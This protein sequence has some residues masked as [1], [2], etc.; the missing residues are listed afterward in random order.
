MRSRFDLDGAIKRILD[1]LASRL[2][3]GILVAG[4][5]GQALIGMSYVGRA[6]SLLEEA[7]AI[8]EGPSIRNGAISASDLYRVTSIS[9]EAAAQGGFDEDRLARFGV[10]VDILYVR[11]DTLRTELLPEQISDDGIEAIDLLFDVVE[12]S[13]LALQGEVEDIQ[14]FAAELSRIAAEAH[15]RLIRYLEDQHTEQTRAFSS[16]LWA[17][18]G[19]SKQHRAFV[20]VNLFVSMTALALLRRE[21]VAR[22]ARAAAEVKLAHLAFHDSLTDLK[23]RAWF[24]EQLDRRFD[25]GVDPSKDDAAGSAQRDPSRWSLIYADLDEFKQ[26]NDIHGHQ[27][28]DLVLAHVANSMNINAFARG[29]YAARLAGD[30]FAMLVPLSDPDELRRLGHRLVQDV[31][32]PINRGSVRI[33]PRISIGIASAKQLSKV[34]RVTPMSLSRAADYALY[35]AKSLHGVMP[36]QLFDAALAKKMQHRRTQL[37]ALDEA[38]K[39]GDLEVWLQPKVAL[40]T[41]QHNSFEALVRWRHSGE[42]I[43]PG[44]FISLAEESGAIVA[45][46]RFMLY[47]ATAEVARWNALHGQDVSVSV[48]LSEL[49]L[50]SPQMEDCVSDAMSSAGLRPE[51]L[52]LELTESVEVRDWPMVSA[53]LNRLRDLGCR[54]S[55]DDFGTGY[56][57]LGYLRQMPADELKLDKSFITDVETSDIAREII[58]AVVAIAQ[59]LELD[60]VAE[61]IETLSQAQIVQDLG[62]TTGQGYYFG[63][64]KLATHWAPQRPLSKGPA[65]RASATTVRLIHTNLRGA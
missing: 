47:A 7:Q 57:S 33:E 10:A 36:V 43:M 41:G 32:S 2:V 62:C 18:N 13:D 3:L 63:R 22:R 46:D 31:A 9:N 39:Q 45:V 30:E 38:I 21:V 64:P 51:L 54:V 28:G 1:L 55:L 44:E 53:R 37:A 4:V 11:T 8:I 52:I 12:Q 24:N 15:S 48:N 35:E 29:G 65:P 20:I 61:G 40:S 16:T 27:V 34:E 50:A 19:V 23:N 60:V 56:S 49:F 14:T 6:T 25:N 5:I 58:S 17:V 26:I 42:L 59:S